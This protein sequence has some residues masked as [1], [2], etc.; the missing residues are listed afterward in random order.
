MLDPVKNAKIV[1]YLFFLFA[2]IDGISFIGNLNNF[3]NPAT[4]IMAVDLAISL[5]VAY[6]LIKTK[7]WAVS[8]TGVLALLRLGEIFYNY[9]VGASPLKGTLIVLAIY[10]VIFFWFFPARKRF[11]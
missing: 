2:L 10:A 11:S 6:G 8:G 1:G 9:S 7:S 4:L 3:S 5:A